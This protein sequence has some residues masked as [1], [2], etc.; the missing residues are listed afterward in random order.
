M[1]HIQQKSQ[2]LCNYRTSHRPLYHIAH[3]SNF[4]SFIGDFP[5]LLRSSLVFCSFLIAFTCVIKQKFIAN[6]KNNQHFIKLTMCLLSFP[7]SQSF[8][9]SYYPLLFHLVHFSM[10]SNFHLPLSHFPFFIVIFFYLFIL[11]SLFIFFSVFLFF[12]FTFSICLS[13]L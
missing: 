2:I 5:F 13:K 1:N 10:N 3:T 11:F 6:T 7:F 9:S 4:F 8:F 12:A